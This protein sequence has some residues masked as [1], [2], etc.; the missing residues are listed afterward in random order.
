MVIIYLQITASLQTKNVSYV[1]ATFQDRC[2]D[3]AHP[4]MTRSR[5]HYALQQ[6]QKG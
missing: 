2:S 4:T 1:A 6:A 5:I 3:T